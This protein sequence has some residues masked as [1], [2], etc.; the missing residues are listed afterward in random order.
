MYDVRP[1]L[2]VGFHGCEEKVRDELLNHPSKFKISDKP[3]DWLG[4]GMYFW[5]NNLE[6]AWEWAEEKK[7]QKKIK[8][9]AVIGAIISLGHCLDFLDSRFIAVATAYYDLMVS[10]YKKVGE[11]IP[12]NK[13]VTGDIHKDKLLRHLDCAVIQYIHTTINQKIADEIA[14]GL[15]V[16][17]KRYDSVRG[18]YE[19]G[20]KAFPGGGLA[21]KS[22]IQICIRNQNCIKGFFL[23]R[24]EVSFGH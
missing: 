2:L 23:P 14:G 9:P 7:K 8:K 20:G 13:D 5:E 12:T 11:S 1:N 4:H 18:V 17:Y 22:H 6:R 16:S 24:T 3:F 15:T 19:E 10:E 21:A